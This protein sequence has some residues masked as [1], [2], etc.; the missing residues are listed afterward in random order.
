MRVAGEEPDSQ[1]QLLQAVKLLSTQVTKLQQELHQVKQSHQSSQ[2]GE[3]SIG[4]VPPGDFTLRSWYELSE[5]HSFAVKLSDGRPV[6]Q[7]IEIR[8]TRR[9]R[10]HKNKFGKNYRSKY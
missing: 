4:D 2:A 6:R 3:F 9:T 10:Q 1:Q 8:V 7:D 5:E